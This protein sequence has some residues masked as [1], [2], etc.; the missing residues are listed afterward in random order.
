MINNFTDNVKFLVYYR[1][2]SSNAWNLTT[3][4]NYYAMGSSYT[5]GYYFSNSSY[6]TVTLSNFIRFAQRLEY[7]VVVQDVNN[8]NIMGYTVFDLRNQN[9]T[10][11]GFSISELDSVSTIYNSRSRMI[12]NLESSY[13]RLRNNS[14]R[15]SMSNTFYQNMQDVINNAS[16]KEFTNYSTYLAAFTDRYTYTISNR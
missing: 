15:I 10:I 9:S 6:G 11:N 13:P 12:S 7:K 16:N 8:A 1:T 2:S 3:S 4:S 5:N 14:N